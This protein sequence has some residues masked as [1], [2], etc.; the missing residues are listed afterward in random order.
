MQQL[1]YVWLQYNT[2]SGPVPDTIG[3]LGET[4]QQLT[5]SNNLLSGELPT[6]FFEL[7]NLELVAL[8]D[9][10]LSASLTKFASLSNL[11]SIY[12]ED[13]GF[14]GALSET[15]IDAWKETLQVL[16]LSTNDL[17]PQRLPAN[18]FEMSQLVVLDLHSNKFFGSL[19]FTTSSGCCNEALRFLAL[20]DNQLSSFLPEEAITYFPM[21]D[22]LDLSENMLTTLPQNLGQLTNLRQLYL[23]SNPFEIQ[24]MPTELFVMRNLQE[25]SLKDA[26]I[27]GTIPPFIAD[28]Q[29]L[30]LLDLD[31]N[32]ISGS[33]PELIGVLE[34]LQVLLLNRNELSGEIPASFAALTN[35]GAYR[36]NP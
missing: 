25:L 4:L 33:I 10:L 32:Q 17:A 6:S 23:G 24:T 30:R 3:S 12:L 26:N 34:N 1:E 19:P 20:Y 21:L 16:D 31:Q 28:L 18:L 8:D 9:N 36:R 15:L 29:F 22:H 35:L 13:N 11:R 27:V 5:L 2:L 7:T 14:Y